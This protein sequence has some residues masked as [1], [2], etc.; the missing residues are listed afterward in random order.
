[1]F[2]IS[3]IVAGKYGN[4]WGSVYE[5]TLICKH[6]SINNFLGALF[7]KNSVH[8][9]INNKEASRLYAELLLCVCWH[10]EHI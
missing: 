4:F 7:T 3:E 9:S 2:I 1:M 6:V 5:K 10:T 8:A